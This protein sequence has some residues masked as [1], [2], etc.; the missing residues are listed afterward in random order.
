VQPLN[1]PLER[2]SSR[3]CLMNVD[4]GCALPLACAAIV[5]P[6][7]HRDV[8]TLKPG[9]HMVCQGLFISCLLDAAESDTE[10]FMVSPVPL[11]MR[12]DQS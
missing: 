11:M 8:T 4:K 1:T 6:E 12:F 3:S 9:E 10:T 2:A 5:A 7:G